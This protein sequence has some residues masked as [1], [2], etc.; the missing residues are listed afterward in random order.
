SRSSAT[1]IHTDNQGLASARNNG[2]AE[3]KGEY[4]LPLDADDLI[5]P[6]YVEK[7]VDLLDQTPDLGIVYCK[8]RLFGAVETEWCL[9]PYSLKAMLQENLIFCSAM[10]RRSDWQDVGGYDPGMVYGWE[11]YE[12]WL[13]LI[14]KGRMVHQIPEMLFAYRV[15]PDSMVRSKEKWQKIAMFKRIYQRHRDLFSEN[16]EVWLD[17]L[18]TAREPYYTSRLYVDCGQGISD[19]TSVSRKIDKTTSNI[20]FDLR[21]HEAPKALRFDPVDVP[22][23]VQVFSYTFHYLDGTEKKIMHFHDNALLIDGKDRFFDHGD[24]QCYPECTIEDLR[25]LVS[26][27]VDLSFKALGEEALAGLVE[28]QKTLMQENAELRDK[29]AQQGGLRAFFNNI[30]KHPQEKIFHYL[31]RQMN[32]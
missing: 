30:K 29:V 8:A 1:I 11:D 2:I 15:A 9:P 14:E 12:F 25:G 22:T 19:Q 10:F 27:S 5:E 21:G 7:A 13:S 18:L 32:L 3:A 16:I 24:S 4:I 28:L 31:K 6:T 20:T 26:V 23:I 17:T